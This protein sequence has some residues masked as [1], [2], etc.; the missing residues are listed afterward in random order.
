MA[1]ISLCDLSLDYTHKVFQRHIAAISPGYKLTAC[2]SQFVKHFH[3]FA[4][5]I[6]FRNKKRRAN[7]NSLKLPQ[8]IV[9]KITQDTQT[10]NVHFDC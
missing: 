4:R 1:V 9:G 8:N 2:T 6:S 7:E 5:Q 3:D 10:S